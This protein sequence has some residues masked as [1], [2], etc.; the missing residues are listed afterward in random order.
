MGSLSAQNWGFRPWR[1]RSSFLGGLCLALPSL[2]ME[3]ISLRGD[4]PKTESP[5]FS[6]VP[7]LSGSVNHSPKLFNRTFQKQTIHKVHVVPILSNGILHHP[8]PS[9]ARPE[10]SLPSV[11]RLYVQQSELFRERERE[12]AFTCL[13]DRRLV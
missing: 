2:S 9:H 1:D 4:A 3:D 6:R 7:I 10:S 13:H 12:T 5:P 8:A 11:P